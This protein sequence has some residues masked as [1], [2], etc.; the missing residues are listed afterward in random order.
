VDEAQ[1]LACTDPWPM[2]DALAERADDRR[3]RLLAAGCCRLPAAWQ[4]LADP[5]SRLAVEVAE[6]YADG[7]ATEDEARRAEA[8]ADA[9]A[10]AIAASGTWNWDVDLSYSPAGLC[11]QAAAQAVTTGPE[12]WAAWAA[13]RARGNSPEERAAQAGLVRC[14]FGNPF[15]TVPIDPA[16]RT[17][18]VL[19][20]AESIY[21]ERA[22]DRL[23][24]LADLLEEAGATDAPLL[25]HLRGP[26][27]HAL[28]CHALDAVVGKG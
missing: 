28:G 3:L 2:L 4:R 18:D 5:R 1:W 10:E 24:I 22:F 9:A 7:L 26:G 17:A 21:Q 11:A 19:R 20:L 12:P 13:R 16:W 6:R 15:R 23:P 25:A 14:I 27:P 8:S